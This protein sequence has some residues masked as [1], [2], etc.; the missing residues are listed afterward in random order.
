MKF[1]NNI[2]ELVGNTPLVKINNINPNK[3]NT[4]FAK[5]EFFNPLHSIKDRTAYGIVKKAIKDGLIKENTTVIEPTSGNTGIALCWLSKIFNFKLILVMPENMSI[6]RQKIFKFF[7]TEVVLTKA[8]HGMSGAIEKA[9][10]ISEKISNS[11]IP[12]QFENNA[13]PQI[14]Y[15]TTGPEIWRDLEGKIDFLICGV[16]SGGTLTGSGRF[17]KERNKEIKIFAVEPE[18]SPFISRRTKGLHKIQGIGAGFLPK[19][20]DLSLI[21]EVI[22]VSDEDAKQYSILLARKEGIFA[23]ISSGACMKAAVEVSKRF[24]NKNIVV[25]LPDTG[26]RYISSYLFEKL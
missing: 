11:F 9:R 18:A 4:I 23:G 5:L 10:E 14:H 20:L 26:E 21:D 12:M 2:S 3:S 22:T 16:G 15:E 1:A 25:I 6:E 8:E 24:D 13:N 7:G 17:L 19:V